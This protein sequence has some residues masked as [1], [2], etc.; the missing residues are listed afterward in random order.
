MALLQF[1]PIDYDCPPLDLVATLV[2]TGLYLLELR[3][4]EVLEAQ[5]N[6]NGVAVVWTAGI[7]HLL[8]SAPAHPIT[9]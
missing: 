9:V 2:S 7:S 5:D 8:S 3:S 1:G 4:P 6:A